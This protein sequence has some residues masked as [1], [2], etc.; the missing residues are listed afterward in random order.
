MATFVA[1]IRQTSPN[2]FTTMAKI[3]VMSNQRRV[4]AVGDTTYYVRDGEQIARQSKNNS[5]YGAGASR[6][7]AQQ[8][9]RV[10]WANLVNFYKACQFWMPKAFESVK[11]GQTM[12]NKF[13]QL[14]IN[15][16]QVGL[17]KDMAQSGCA[18]LQPYQVSKGSLPAIEVGGNDVTAVYVTSIRVTQAISGSTT[19]GALA[20]DIIANNQEFQNGDNIAIVCFNWFKDAQQ[21][22]YVRSAYYEVTLNTSS[23]VALSAALPAGTLTKS[24]SDTLGIITPD[25][26]LD[27]HAIT[28][29]HT[30]KVSGQLKVSTSFISSPDFGYANDYTGE[31]WIQECIDSY[32]VDIEVPLDPNFKYG[33]ITSVTANGVAVTNAQ[34]LSG[35]QELRVYVG[36]TDGE[37]VRL[38]FNGVEYTPLFRGPGYLGYILGDNGTCQIYSGESLY[39]SFTVSGIA[40]PSNL[41][42]NMTGRQYTSNLSGSVNNVRFTG[43]CI[44]YPYLVR[45]DYPVYRF[46]FGDSEDP[47]GLETIESFELIN[48]EVSSEPVFTEES[49]LLRVMVTDDSEVA[50]IKYNGFIV[51]VFNYTN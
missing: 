1:H 12:Y 45:E 17:T 48:C 32:G 8:R 50:Y 25:G 26:V 33:T 6:S 9:R 40:V 2:A 49:A 3:R 23:T 28:V 4:G 36:D 46:T 39:M 47:F 13:M 37:G 34:S 41:P 20:T 30:R 16:S 44:N 22:P 7:E 15:E 11:P 10:K 35:S 21:Y 14:N 5:N 51:A 38:T 19:V 24:A 18:V 43:N 29:I 27:P 31:E 42:T